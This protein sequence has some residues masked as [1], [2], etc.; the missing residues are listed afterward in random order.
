M[1]TELWTNLVKISFSSVLNDPIFAKNREKSYFRE[2]NSENLTS[3]SQLFIT[4][5]PAYE[6]QAQ[7]QPN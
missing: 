6:K 1:S 3:N 2:K 5:A 4:F 7:Q